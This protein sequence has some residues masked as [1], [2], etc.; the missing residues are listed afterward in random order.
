MAA[1]RHG[2]TSWLVA[3][4]ARAVA[5]IFAGAIAL[6]T[7]L[8]KLPV[9]SAHRSPSWIDALFT[10]TSAVCVTG[11]TVVDTGGHWSAFGEVV[12]LSLIQ[13]GGL[14]I[15]TMASVVVL[16][17]NRRLGL[18]ARHLAF[19]ERS[20]GSSGEVRPLLVAVI[21]FTL[22]FEAVGAALLFVGF[23]HAH[24][25]GVATDAWHAVFHSVSAFNNAGFG[26]R[27]DS[28]VAYVDHWWINLVISTLVIGGGLGFPVLLELWARRPRR[29]GRNERRALTLHTRLTLVTVGGL[30]AV[31]TVALLAAEWSNHAT[32][33]QSSVP[34]RVLAMFFQSVQARTAGFNSVDIGQMNTVSWM[35]LSVLMFIGGG[36][37]STA[38]G[39]KVTTFALVAMMIW[40][41]IRGDDDVTLFGRRVPERTQRRAVAI[42]A[43]SMGAVV[44][45][46]MALVWLSSTTL[47]RALFEVTSAFGTAGLS[48]GIT[49]GLPDAAL[50]ILIGLMYL[51]RLGPL[52]LGAALVMRERRRRY[53]YPEEQPILG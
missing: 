32:V 12:V 24:E 33:G 37:A 23:R 3:N 17:L 42:A 18:G 16:A 19:A 2:S 45:C 11:L 46:G 8:L 31:G 49:A 15:M 36:S 47:D 28:L 27:P 21:R 43:I 14:G 4:P 52:T 7:T 20:A 6:G 38:G 1:P 34:E 10:A 5:L 25:R 30:L 50:A 35:L 39:I 9:S 29:G 13:I 51:G 53:R 48:T 22:V 40:S 41:E 44:V 26:L